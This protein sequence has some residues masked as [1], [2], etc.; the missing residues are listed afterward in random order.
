MKLYESPEWQLHRLSAL[1]ILTASGDSEEWET[2]MV[3]P[4][5]DDYDPNADET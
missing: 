1:S 4:T 3:P 5:E 2:D